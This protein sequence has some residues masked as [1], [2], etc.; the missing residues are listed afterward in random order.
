[1]K[2][3]ISVLLAGVMA[4]SLA[5]CSGNKQADSG[6]ASKSAQAASEAKSEAAAQSSAKAETSE[7]SVE[8]NVLMLHIIGSIEDSQ[9]VEDEINAYIEPLI[10]ATVKF[11]WLDLGDYVDQINVKLASGDVIDVLPNFSMMMPAMYASESIMP[12]GDLV[13]QY[14]DGIVA[15]LGEDY[16]NCGKINGELYSIPITNAFAQNSAFIYR[17]DIAEELNLDFSNVKTL[18]DMEGIFEQVQAAHPELTMICCNSFTDPQL[19]EYDWEGLSDEYG[20]LMDPVNSTEVVDLFETEEYMDYCKLM[21]D[22]Y[23]KGY[24]QSDC[25]TCTEQLTSLLDSGLY[26]GTIA[27]DYPGNVEE[28]FGTSKYQIKAVQLTEQISTTTLVTNNVMTIPTTSQNPEK[29]MQFINLL[30]TDEKVQNLISYGIEGEHY[31]LVDG[32][33]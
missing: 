33:A 21:N 10:N 30:Y 26:F 13:A 8:L 22:W 3:V 4:L 25:A 32:K 14:G 12:L 16:L 24:I 2:K 18:E 11:E 23:S 5:A 6:S 7:E 15:A 28:K 9:K 31:R 1:M 27:K 20:V 29:A 19:R 17:Q